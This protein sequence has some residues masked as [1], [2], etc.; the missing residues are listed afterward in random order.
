MDINKLHE[1]LKKSWCVETCSPALKECWNYS[2]PSLGQCAVTALVVNYY[3]GGKIMRC[4]AE[5]GSHYYNLID[6]KVVDL[7]SEQFIEKPDYEN[8]EERKRDYLLSN[9]DTRER[10]AILQERLYEA[11]REEKTKN[12]LRFYLLSTKLKYKIRTGWDKNHWNINSERLESV[13]EHVYG[14]CILATSLNSEFNFNLDMEKV[15]NMLILHEIGEVLIPDITPFDGITAEEKAKMEHQAMKDVLG[16]IVS[17]DKFY[18]L[19]LEFDEHKT[20]ESKFAYLCD[21]MEADLQA[22]VYQDMG[23]QHS[24]DDQK[25][26]VVFNSPKAV[27]MVKDGA[28][29][30][31]DIWYE[32]DKPKYD[33]EPVFQRVLSYIKNNNTNL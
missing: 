27:K 12:A 33:G 10:Y 18:D 7:T 32:W 26:N 24:L 14:T 3:F 9:N 19:L 23:C 31:F 21:K 28:K 25:N 30:A 22:K 17:K 13:A 1:L 15:Q 6:D 29:T 20:R 16:D 8:G 4:M 11:K 2:N 5:S